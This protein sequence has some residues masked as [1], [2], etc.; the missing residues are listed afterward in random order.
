MT[1]EPRRQSRGEVFVSYA[2]ERCSKD[3]GV[4]ARLRRADNP[5]TEYQSWD[6]L[7]QFGIDLE[8]A[9][10]RVPFA[11]VAASLART[12]SSEDGKAGLGRALADCY[13]EGNASD[14]AKARLRR[15]LACDAVD[16][17][18]RVLRP[19]LS[20]I[21]SRGRTQ[22]CHAHLLDDLLRFRWNQQRVK[23]R[24]AQD[25][26]RRHSENES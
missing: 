24:W 1:E 9:W 14:Q 8:K 25:F 22:V 10:E 7:A 4:A 6:F 20:L 2:L 12:R 15:I 16:E 19:V 17:L 3:T 23:V 18:C 5:S 21:A 11:C 13:E 26:H